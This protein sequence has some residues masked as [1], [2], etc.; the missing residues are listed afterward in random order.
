MFTRDQV[1]SIQIGSMIAQGWDGR[2]GKPTK[3]V[4]I[5]AKREDVHGKL[6]VCGYREY[7]PNAKISFSIKEGDKTDAKIYKL[8]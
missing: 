1:D 2:F 4:E 3:V 5:F 6:F 8:A 7:G